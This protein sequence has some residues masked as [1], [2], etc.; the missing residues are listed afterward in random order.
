MNNSNTQHETRHYKGTRR[1][2]NHTGKDNSFIDWCG[3]NLPDA[4]DYWITDLDAMP[5]VIRNRKGHLMLLEIKR[6]GRPISRAQKRSFQVLNRLLWAGMDATGGSLR[7]D[8]YGMDLEYHGFHCLTFS[9]T[10]FHDGTA[11]WDGVLVSEAEATRL[12]SFENVRRVRE[13]AP[14]GG[15]QSLA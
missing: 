15:F 9:N 5:Y 4:L 14:Q 11:Y 7:I 13:T 3:T 8:G 2:T 10:G 6:K 12:L 1:R